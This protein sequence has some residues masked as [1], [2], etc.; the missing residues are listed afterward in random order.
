MELHEICLCFFQ[1]YLLCDS[2][3]S[4]VRRGFEAVLRAGQAEHSLV[5]VGDLEEHLGQAADQHLGL[6]ALVGL[7]QLRP[8]HNRR[9]KKNVILRNRFLLETSCSLVQQFVTKQEVGT[10][11]QSSLH[12]H[13]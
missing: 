11:V 8:E 5:S 2:I 6:G 10:S 9:R 4:V 3:Y 7:Q 1:P 13:K 12:L